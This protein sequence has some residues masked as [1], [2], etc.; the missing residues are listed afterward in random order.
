MI[1]QGG[2]GQ[3]AIYLSTISTL[4]NSRLYESPTSIRG[5]YGFED[6]TE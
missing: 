3:L 1:A 2:G 6:E 5:D 4:M